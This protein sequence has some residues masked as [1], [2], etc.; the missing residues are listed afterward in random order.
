MPLTDEQLMQA[1]I[2]TYGVHRIKH[3]IFLCCDQRNPK[4]C[5]H[6]SGLQSWEY[7]KTRI[8]E[9][10]KESDSDQVIYRTKANCLRV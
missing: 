10:N 1:R 9:V 7:L 3:H 2:E 5:E 4:C 6:E 8:N